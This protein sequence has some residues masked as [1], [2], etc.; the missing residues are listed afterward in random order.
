MST[1]EIKTKSE[2]RYVLGRPGEP[3]PS[4]E[5]VDFKTRWGHTSLL[6]VGGSWLFRNKLYGSGAKLVSYDTLEDAL[7]HHGDS[8]D[9]YEVH[10][11]GAKSNRVSKWIRKVDH[12]S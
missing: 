10:L 12:V 4:D 11:R 1:K 6:S 8:Y 3:Y 7:Q 2:S 5:I 9:V